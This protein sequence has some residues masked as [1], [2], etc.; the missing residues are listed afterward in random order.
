MKTN[1][2]DVAI[3][4]SAKRLLF[5]N[6]NHFKEN[7]NYETANYLRLFRKITNGLLIKLVFIVIIRVN[8]VSHPGI[9]FLFIFAMKRK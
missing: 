1:H 9:R 2:C 3:I 8:Y 7:K 6:Q 4:T 5:I